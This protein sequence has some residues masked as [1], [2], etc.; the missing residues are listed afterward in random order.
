MATTSTSM[1]WRAKIAA[2]WEIR[3]CE[4]EGSIPW[5]QIA[6]T[7]SSMESGASDDEFKRCLGWD[8]SSGEEALR[9]AKARYWCKLNGFHLES[10][11]NE[12]SADMYNDTNIDWYPKIDPKISLALNR[13]DDDDAIVNDDDAIINEGGND[14]LTKDYLENKDE[15]VVIG[16]GSDHNDKKEE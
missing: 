8:A 1:I 12:E 15:K 3:Y 11:T 10:V 13:W 14:W 2:A 5:E 6:T 7:Q 4:E 9:K 16:W